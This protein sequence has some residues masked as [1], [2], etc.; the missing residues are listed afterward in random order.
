MTVDPRNVTLGPTGRKLLRIVQAVA[1]DAPYNYYITSGLRSTNDHHG[2]LYYGGS[3]TAAIDIGFSY[4]T[5]GY[6]ARARWLASRLYAMSALT[7]ELIVTDVG[8]GLSQGGYY[9][10]NTRRVGAYAAAAHRNHIHFASSSALA[11]KML[12]RFMTQATPPL[13]SDLDLV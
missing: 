12:S 13:F 10:K 5:A 6:K 1:A 7:V 4:G 2:G 11:D 8:S 3:P 9:V